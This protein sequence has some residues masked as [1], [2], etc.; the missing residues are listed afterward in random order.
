MGNYAPQKHTK[1]R[2]IALRKISA[3]FGELRFLFF[4]EKMQKTAEISPLAN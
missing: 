3:N 2:K 4:T 1:T